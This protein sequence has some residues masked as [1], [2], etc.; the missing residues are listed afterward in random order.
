MMYPP[1]AFYRILDY[2]I[3]ACLTLRCYGIDTFTVG[4]GLNLVT[5]AMLYLIGSTIVLM[6][7]SVYLSYVFPGEYGVK[8]SPFFP[9]IGELL[10]ANLIAHCFCCIS[11]FFFVFVVVVSVFVVV[12]S[13]VVVFVLSV[14]FVVSVVFVAIVFLSLLFLSL[15]LSL[16]LSHCLCL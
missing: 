9:I 6:I 10:N 4:S 11:C 7:L 1:F 12:V 14:V 15:L 3:N 5:T 13:V 16:L 2:L 8:K